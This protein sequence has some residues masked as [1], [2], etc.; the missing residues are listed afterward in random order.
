MN[1]IRNKF[2]LE[3]NPILSNMTASE[4]KIEE[5]MLQDKHASVERNKT[6]TE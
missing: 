5:K 2:K 3:C 1:K 6:L 4:D